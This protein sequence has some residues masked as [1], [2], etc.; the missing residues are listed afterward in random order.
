MADTDAEVEF[1][2]SSG[3]KNE[4]VGVLLE[5]VRESLEKAFNELPS[6]FSVF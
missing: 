2:T 3:N 6:M 5:Q 1:V 4:N